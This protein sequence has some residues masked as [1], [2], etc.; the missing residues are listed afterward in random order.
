MPPRRN[1]L[2]N[3][4]YDHDLEQCLMA[5]M[6]E[7]LDQVVD[8]L[9]DRMVEL[10]NRGRQG[11]QTHS[12]MDDDELGNP[13]GNNDDSSS[14]GN[15]EGRRR[16]ERGVDNRRWEAGMRVDIPEFDGWSKL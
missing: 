6:D 10:M 8:Q 11:P 1:R 3:E 16:H 7:R 5:R 15:L 4:V 14:E 2:F 9:T 12:Q 13:F